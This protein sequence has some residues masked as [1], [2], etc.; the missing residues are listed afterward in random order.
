MARE[1]PVLLLKTCLLY[2][3]YA[4]A[5]FKK[6]VNT[7][8]FSMITAECVCLRSD[9]LP[10]L[11]ESRLSE[12]RLSESSFLSLNLGDLGDLV[13]NDDESSVSF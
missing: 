1:F 8:L 7:L 5:Y 4:I 10:R 9:L 3:A 2:E 12:S 6:Q 11:S 13:L